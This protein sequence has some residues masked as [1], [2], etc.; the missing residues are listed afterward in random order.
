[1]S[2]NLFGSW[3]NYQLLEL[4]IPYQNRTLGTVPDS[5]IIKNYSFDIYNQ[6]GK[7]GFQQWNIHLQSINNLYLENNKVVLSINIVN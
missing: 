7:D 2:I 1:M 5:F 6:F 3:K 4:P